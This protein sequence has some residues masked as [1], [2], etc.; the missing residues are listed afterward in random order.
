MNNGG[1]SHLCLLTPGGYQCLCPHGLSLDTTGTK[2]VTGNNDESF[3]CCLHGTLALIK[4]CSIFECKS[5]ALT[6]QMEKKTTVKNARLDLGYAP[7]KLS[8]LP[9]MQ[10]LK[11]E[12]SNLSKRA[13]ESH[14]TLTKTNFAVAFFPWKLYHIGLDHGESANPCAP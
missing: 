2:C 12:L 8:S 13:Y 4:K 5:A 11:V 7:E 6:Y 10:V 1:C 14:S 3:D 9:A